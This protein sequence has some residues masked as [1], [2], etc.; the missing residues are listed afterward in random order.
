MIVGDIEL[1]T[2]IAPTGSIA[3][4]KRNEIEHLHRAVGPNLDVRGL[5]I[6]MND[7]LLV[8]RFE[9]FGDLL[10]DGQ[11]FVD[12][13]GAARNP[14]RQIVALD[15]LEDECRDP[16]ALFESVDRRDIG[17]VDRGED[18][19]FAL[20]TSESFGISGHQSGQHL[21]RHLAFQVRVSGLI[22]VAMPPT[23]ICAVIW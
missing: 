23:P 8:R 18:F 4:A 21:D 7:P 3:F 19:R 9:D 5:Q 12:R 15:E 11:C 20:E 22:D 10:G 17:M 14:L 1:L 6:A 16:V 13:D 2:A